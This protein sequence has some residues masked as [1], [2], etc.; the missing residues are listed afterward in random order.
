MRTKRRCTHK[1]QTKKTSGLLEKSW[2]GGVGVIVSVCF[3]II[4]VIIA[5]A[6]FWQTERIHEATE[7]MTVE[8]NRQA[9][10][11]RM[12]DNVKWYLRERWYD[13]AIIES[14]VLNDSLSSQKQRLDSIAY[15]YFYHRQ[16]ENTNR[17]YKLAAEK[18]GELRKQVKR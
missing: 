16:R 17:G 13:R 3:S 6:I 11:Q 14:N 15:F 12:K 8:M 7:R 5:I 4:S 9:G 1:V 18:F 10:I 2:W